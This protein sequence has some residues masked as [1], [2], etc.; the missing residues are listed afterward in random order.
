[1]NQ[2]TTQVWPTNQ[3]PWGAHVV[4]E[5]TM[6]VDSR[7]NVREVAARAAMG[8][9]AAVQYGYA[10]VR[11]GPFDLLL[12]VIRTQ[13]VEAALNLETQLSFPGL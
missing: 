11:P 6:Q 8:E 13:M 12:D 5:L 3:R 10:S 2:P 7:G 4:W 1:M 9:G